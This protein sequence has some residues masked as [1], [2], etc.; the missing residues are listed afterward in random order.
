MVRTVRD[1]KLEK[2]EQRKRLAIR[3]EPYWRGIQEGWHLGYYKGKREGTWVARWRP[4]GGRY[5]KRTLGRS[6]DIEEAD[7]VT[8]LDYKQ[9]QDQ[10]R[11]WFKTEERRHFGADLFGGRYTVA[12]ALEHY[13]EWIGTEGKFLREAQYSANGLIAPDLGETELT[14]LTP[15][16][17]KAWHRK[18][19]NSPPR[20]RTRPGKE[21]RFRATDLSHPDVVRQRRATANRVLTTLKAALNHAY[22]EG[23]VHSDDAWRRVTPFKNV[24]AARIRYLTQD[25]CVRLVNT[26]EPDLR[27]L[28][29]GALFTGCRYSELTSLQVADF[30]PD[31]GTVHGRASKGGRARHVYLADDG[32]AFFAEV[33][34]GRRGHDPI[35][36]K[37]DGEPWGK[38]HQIR[39]LRAVCTRAQIK[40][41]IGFH[42]LRHTYSSHLIMAGVPL[43]VVA[44][45]LGHS[46]TRMVEKHYAHLA[47]SWVREKIREVAPPLGIH[48]E[49]TVTP[50]PVRQK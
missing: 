50:L 32:R 22:R 16:Q 11:E 23:R 43:Q 4:P 3:H 48:Q 36:L 34:A 37:P 31:S 24:D 26:C 40:P 44:E 46:D 5:Q 7:G 1:S 30:N 19:A 2:P 17:I 47:Q 41:S 14:K 28:V 33:T 21:Q 35:F 18:L 38:G 12:H 27:R 13:L 45:N 9:A 42:G 8:V 25:E 29:Q 6:D 10:A 20:L 15:Q 49:G 39:P